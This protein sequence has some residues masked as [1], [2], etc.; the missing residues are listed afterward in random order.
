MTGGDIYTIAGQTAPPGTPAT[1]ARPA[2]ATLDG[3]QGV[4]VD[5]AGNLVIA[6]TGNSAIR[7]IAAT[8]ARSTASR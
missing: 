4:T 3:P 2:S 7:V 1:A 6:D 8:T 5:A